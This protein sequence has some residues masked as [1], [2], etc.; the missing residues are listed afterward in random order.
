MEIKAKFHIIIFSVSKQKIFTLQVISK[1]DNS[2]RKYITSKAYID[3]HL[4]NQGRGD[5]IVVFDDMDKFIKAFPE[6]KLSEGEMSE[7]KGFAE[8]MEY[9]TV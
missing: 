9:F 4:K 6:N 5:N 2:T 1:F 7:L 8:S 3:K